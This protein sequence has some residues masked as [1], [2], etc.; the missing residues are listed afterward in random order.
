M[1]GSVPTYHIFL[2]PLDIFQIE[3][4]CKLLLVLDHLIQTILIFFQI[5][6]PLSFVPS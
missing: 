1:I 2:F 5:D 3:F 4:T 6:L